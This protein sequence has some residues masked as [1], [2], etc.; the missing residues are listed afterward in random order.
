MTANGT[1][2]AAHVASGRGH[3]RRTGTAGILTAAALFVMTVAAASAWSA[4]VP[5]AGSPANASSVDFG[6]TGRQTFE[7]PRLA[8]LPGETL[9][10]R[11]VIENEGSQRVRYSLVSESSNKDGKAVRDILEVTIR[12]ADPGTIGS[13]ASCD[14]FDG[15]VLYEGAL[16]ASEARVGDPGMG[17]NAG[18]RELASGASEALCIEVRLPL[19]ADNAYQGATTST[20]FVVDA[21]QTAGNA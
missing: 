5:G 8:L 17:A 14:R 4:R 10:H 13:L 9:R 6:G 21:E 19:S 12:A 3:A 15:D 18:D 1:N 7:L 20:T 16:G 11:Q 2:Q